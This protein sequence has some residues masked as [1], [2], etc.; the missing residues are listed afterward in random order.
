MRKKIYITLLVLS[1]LFPVSVKAAEPKAA[2]IRADGLWL[3]EGTAERRLVS[4]SGLSKPKWSFDGKY[5][6][7][8]DFEGMLWAYSLR[9]HVKKKVF[10]SPV[11]MAQWAPAESTIAFKD[12]SILNIRQLEPF[13]PFSNVALGT[14]SYSWTPDGKGFIVSSNASLTPAGW[15]NVSIF[16][17]PKDAEGNPVKVKQ[18]AELPAES[19]DFFAIGTTPFLFSSNKN[20]MAFIACPTASFSADRNFLSLMTKEGEEF[21]VIG[22]MLAHLKWVKWSPTGSL[23]AFIEGEGRLPTDNKKLTIYSKADN[24]KRSYTPAGYADGDFTWN[25]MTSIIVSRQKESGWNIPKEKRPKPHLVSV[26]LMTGASRNIT[27]P[28]PQYGDTLPM[29]LADG[30]L[31]WERNKSGSDVWQSDRNVKNSRIWIKNVKS[32]QWSIFQPN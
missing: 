29:S 10:H 28:N 23:L 27:A 21:Q 18:L 17:V 5:I 31:Y 9:T 20:L 30:T 4:E 25:T 1:I 6:S 32:E 11:S 8:N 16:Y 15:T 7:Y 2:F 12:S 14:G 26:N 3:K 22:D 24:K 19:D 13:T